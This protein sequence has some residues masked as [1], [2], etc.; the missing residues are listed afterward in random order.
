MGIKMSDL[1]NYDSKDNKLKNAD[2]TK[3]S[4]T[5]ETNSVAEVLGVK[6]GRAGAMMPV[7][8]NKRKRFPIAVDIIVGV[9]MIAAVVALIIGAYMLFKFYSDDYRGTDIS[10]TV[11]C[12]EDDLSY[13]SD[14][15]NSEIYC[16]IA[17]SSLYFG[18]VKSIKQEGESIVLEIGLENV[19]FRDGNGY[20]VGSKR[21]AVGSE[22]TLRCGEKTIQ[23]TV[24]E[25][26]KAQNGVK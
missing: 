15:S 22:L 1:K 10:Y 12:P 11:V 9:L 4:N 25:L 23:G 17:G 14:M 7:A 20:T 3:M 24:V 13:F 21:L 16:D 19:K 26:A 18:K 5:D 2:A 6:K 8:S